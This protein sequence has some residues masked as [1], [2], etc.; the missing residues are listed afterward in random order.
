MRNLTDALKPY[1]KS[2]ITSRVLEYSVEES[3]DVLSD[4]DLVMLKQFKLTLPGLEINFRSRLNEKA[5]EIL[6]KA[7]IVKLKMV[8]NQI[9]IANVQYLA[10][11]MEDNRKI[12]DL[13]L[14]WSYLG[15]EL[16]LLTNA[17]KTNSCL[18]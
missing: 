13:D 16:N 12:K 1:G 9:D 15:N 3:V 11:I 7:S 8:R 6:R 14:T 17:L 18:Q 10:H 2:F 5:S 4:D